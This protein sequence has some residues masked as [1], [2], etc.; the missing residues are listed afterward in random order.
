[1]TSQFLVKQTLDTKRYLNTGTITIFVNAIW[2][3]YVDLI[4][5]IPTY[6][7]K[8]IKFKEMP[9]DPLHFKSSNNLLHL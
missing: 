7:M 1:M 3:T 4:K 2:K 5:K 8:A 6:L 9:P